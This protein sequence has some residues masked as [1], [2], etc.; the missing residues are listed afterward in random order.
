LL[1]KLSAQGWLCW[2]CDMPIDDGLGAGWS[3][4]RE[5]LVPKHKGGNGTRE[6][7][8]AVHAACNHHRAERAGPPSSS[9]VQHQRVNYLRRIAGL[10][11]EK[12]YSANRHEDLPN[13]GRT[14]EGRW[15]WAPQYG[16]IF[17]PQRMSATGK[18]D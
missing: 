10:Y 6:N 2:W 9:Y 7:I 3:A 11:C 12:P 4:T 1:W 5:H 17:G 18:D 13:F 8:V 15:L 16:I 14:P